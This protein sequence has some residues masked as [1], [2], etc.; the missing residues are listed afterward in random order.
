MLEDKHIGNQ[1][2]FKTINLKND[3]NGLFLLKLKEI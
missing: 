2:Y 1:E 3:E